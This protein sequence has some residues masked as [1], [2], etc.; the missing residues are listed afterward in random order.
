MTGAALYADKEGNVVVQRDRRLPTP[1][2]GEILIETLFSGVNPADL[3][4]VRY[5]GYRE[6]FLGSDFCGRVLDSPGLADS[7]IRV[8]DIVAGVNIAPG[9]GSRD[10]GSHKPYIS[11]PKTGLI[12]VPKGMPI[13]DAAALT[14][15][16]QT[17]NDALYNQFELPLPGTTQGP[18]EGT[19]VIWGGGTG[20]G[21]SAVQLARASGV[22]S[23]IVTAS[24]IRHA[25]LCELGATEC[26]DYKDV[27]VVQM[28]KRAIQNTGSSRV[29]G[30]ETAGPPEAASA[31]L[32]ALADVRGEVRFSWVSIPA[33]RSLDE[34]A[35]GTRDYELV[36]NVPGGPYVFPADPAK[37]ER[38]WK[39]ID[40]VVRNYGNG[41][42]L[43][44]V[45]VFEGTGEEAL[46][47][48]EKVAQQGIFGKLVLKHPLQ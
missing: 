3:K 42:R 13:P 45:R 17:A 30:F 31:L 40:W 16:V 32:D 38:M 8:G 24:P 6:V 35:L 34:L 37:A 44:V 25:L 12:K 1:R 36:F 4:V 7:S 26:F 21:L 23:I 18:T 14:C 46:G 47:E 15:V 2:D 10:Y 9:P 29:W 43:P 19:M 41:F 33:Q 22:S 27:D 5:L 39:S 20:V 48:M 28:V 11:T